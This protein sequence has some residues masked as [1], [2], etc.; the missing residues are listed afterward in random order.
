[1]KRLVMHSVLSTLFIIAAG[2]AAH[3]CLGELQFQGYA[4]NVEGCK[5]QVYFRMARPNQVCPIILED[6]KEKITGYCGVKEGDEVSGVIVRHE[7]GSY[8]ID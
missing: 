6:I 1:M 8:S 2:S 7:D 3:A 4:R 5:F